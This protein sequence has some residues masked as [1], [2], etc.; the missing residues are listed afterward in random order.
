MVMGPLRIENGSDRRR[1]RVGENCRHR[2]RGDIRSCRHMPGRVVY[3]H[4]EVVNADAED[5]G[6]IDLVRTERSPIRSCGRKDDR[7][8]CGSHRLFTPRVITEVKIEPPD[9]SRL[10]WNL[11]WRWMMVERPPHV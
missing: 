1:I 9:E 10:R 4:V 7:N 6:V 11:G 2:Y 3:D 5:I 8:R